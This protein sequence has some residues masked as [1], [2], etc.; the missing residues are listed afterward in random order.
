MPK[1]RLAPA[2]FPRTLRCNV[3]TWTWT[4]LRKLSNPRNCPNCH[5]RRWAWKPEYIQ[6]QDA[7][8]ADRERNRRAAAARRPA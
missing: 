7:L 4:Q 1:L 3:C 5:S 6:F 8:K 2:D